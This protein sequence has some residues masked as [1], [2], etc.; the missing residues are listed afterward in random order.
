M[1]EKLYKVKPLEW[2]D[3]QY[4]SETDTPFGRYGVEL[5]F[6]GF[7]RSPYWLDLDDNHTNCASLEAGKAACESHWRTKLA[8][9]LE[10]VD[11]ADTRRLDWMEE[12]RRALN[13][14]Y[15]TVYG[16]KLVQS[17][18]VTRLMLPNFEV[19]LHDSAV[20]RTAG[21]TDVRAAIDAAMEGK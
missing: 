9:V 19:D 5:P 4:G 14:H 17:N 20:T 3:F 16:W 8:E 13:N 7:K 6:P 1:S 21:G 15:G 11:E 10:P 18:N 12:R 2:V